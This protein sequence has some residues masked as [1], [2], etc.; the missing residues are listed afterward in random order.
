MLSDQDKKRNSI[1]RFLNGK[2][3]ATPVTIVLAMLPAEPSSGC[4]GHPSPRASSRVRHLLIAA[5]FEG[6]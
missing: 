5:P 2:R 4:S 3:R 1:Q 6:E